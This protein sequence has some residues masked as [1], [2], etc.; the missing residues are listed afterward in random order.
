MLGVPKGATY[1]DQMRY[2]LVFNGQN[3]LIRR[4]WRA[5]KFG[6]FKT[7]HVEAESLE[8]AELEGV[9]LLRGDRDLQRQT[10]NATGDPPR[11]ILDSHALLPD[12]QRLGTM[13]G[14]TWYPE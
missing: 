1:N 9:E 4:G 7:V 5:R 14:A 6:F 11:L 12:G 3:F 13:P 10:R 2:K 8:A